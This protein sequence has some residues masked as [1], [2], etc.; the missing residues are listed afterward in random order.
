MGSQIVILFAVVLL[1]R[2]HQDVDVLVNLKSKH[3]TLESE[4]GYSPETNTLVR[5]GGPEHLI[6]ADLGIYPK[7]IAMEI[8][9]GFSRVSFSRDIFFWT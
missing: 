7:N 3:L 4:A 5:I 9:D 6:G 8:I 1:I 2:A